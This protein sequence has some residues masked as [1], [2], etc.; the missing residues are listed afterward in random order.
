MARKAT[1]ATAVIEAHASTAT[2]VVTMSD[3]DILDSMSL[4]HAETERHATAGKKEYDAVTEEEKAR[5]LKVLGALDTLCK[6]YKKEVKDGVMYTILGL[7]YKVSVTMSDA[8]KACLIRGAVYPVQYGSDSVAPFTFHRPVKA[9]EDM[10]KLVNQ[11]RGV[12]NAHTIPEIKKA[13][14]IKVP[15]LSELGFD[16]E[17]EEP[18]QTVLALDDTQLGDVVLEDANEEII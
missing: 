18:V 9:K 7:K 8:D 6:G 17:E 12:M 14:G 16:F 4:G 15:T 1:S 2:D 3:K 11:I 13:M 10:T 5:F